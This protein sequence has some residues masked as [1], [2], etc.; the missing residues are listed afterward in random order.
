MSASKI[1][2][3]LHQK[4]IANTAQKALVHDLSV[5]LCNLTYAVVKGVG[6]QGYHKV[7]ISTKVLKHSYDKRPAFEYDLIISEIHKMVRYPDKIYE[8][9]K[10][11][12]GDYCFVKIVR[13]ER[14]LCVVEK[15]EQQLEVVTFYRTPKEKYLDSF[16]L[17]WSWRDDKSP[18]RDTLDSGGSRPTS[19]PQ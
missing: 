18:H 16:L 19:A 12:R 11:K 15:G 14:C 5:F 3:N 13:N 4:Y 8:N 10:G 1:V 2:L 6:L 17:V 7:Y 9:K